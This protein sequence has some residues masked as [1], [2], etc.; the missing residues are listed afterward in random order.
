MGIIK[1][2][3][4]LLHLRDSFSQVIRF[5]S[6]INPPIF[7]FYKFILVYFLIQIQVKV[8]SQRFLFPSNPFI[9]TI[10]PPIFIFYKFILV[11]F[12]IQIQVKVSFIQ[13]YLS[14]GRQ[15][16]IQKRPS[17]FF[18]IIEKVRY[19]FVN[20]LNKIHIG[21]KVILTVLHNMK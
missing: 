8:A 16:T 10:N 20:K 14:M 19:S 1:F 4:G 2:V 5:I 9:S 12:L 13:F 15:V 6:T 11:Y 18:K 3:N 7:I 17:I 21:G